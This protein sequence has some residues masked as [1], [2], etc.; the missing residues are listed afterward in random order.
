[1]RVVSLLPSATEHLCFLGAA[2]ALAGRSHECD[3]PPEA[4]A[5]PVLTAARIPAGASPGQTDAMVREELAAGRSLYTLDE[6]LLERL[7]PDLIITQDLCNVC[8][9]DL[10]A[11]RR[12]AAGMK[13][14]PEVLSLN[15]QTMEDVLEDLLN[16]G[17][18]VGLASE[19][20]KAV[21]GLRERMYRASDY[22]NP[23]LDGPNV[24]FLEWTDPLFAGGHWTPQ[25]IER[26]GGRHPLN[27]TTAKEGSGAAVG[28][29]QTARRAGKS[30]RVAPEVLAASRPDRLIICP[31]GVALPGVREMA[32]D[33]A[34]APWWA[35]LPAVG[36]SGGAGVALV[37]G[38]QMF[39]RPGP[40]LV[41][42]FEWLVGWLN[43]RPELIPD[44][45]PWEPWGG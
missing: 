42:A 4:L 2:G 33:L 7:E 37:D 1:M 12:V 17:Q 35:D 30:M 21:V 28:P 18:A 11:V 19:A 16:V 15:P 40:R 9:I 8:S 36:R 38:N 20:K 32:R 13:R 6:A 31:C 39:N 44:G 14:P 10:A 34:A 3:F 29:Q 41:D 26:A 24:A 27:P 5:A 45:F 43:N 23:Y 22:V 25:L